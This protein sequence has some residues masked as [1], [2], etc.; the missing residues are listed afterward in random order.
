MGY[1]LHSRLWL[2]YALLIAMVLCLVGGAIAIV[3]FRSNIPLQQ[4][5]IKLQ[6]LRANTLPRLRLSSNLNSIELQSL[7]NRNTDQIRGRIVI[8]SNRGEVI[9]DSLS[10][11][12]LSLPDFGDKPPK[13]EVGAL[14]KFYRD[15]NRRGWYYIID[16]ISPN[17]LAFFGVNRPPLQLFAIFRDQYLRPLVLGGL[18]A[19]L[20]SIAFS[21]I[22][23]HW[24]STPLKQISQE[25]GQVA[26]GQAHPIPPRGPAEVRSLAAAFND[27]Y[28]QVQNSRQSQ[29]DFVAN[30][31]HELKTPLTSIQGFARAI[32]DG[33][34]ETEA[35]L[36][37]AATVIENEAGRMDRLVSDLLALAKMDA[38]TASFSMHEINLVGLLQTAILKFTPLIEEASLRFSTTLPSNNINI[39]GDP[40]RLMQVLD[41]LLVNAIKFT[42]ENGQISLDCQ[43][44]KNAVEIHV[45]DTGLGIPPDEQER[46]FERFYQVDKARSGD[47]GYGL[48]LAISKQIVETHGGDIFLKSKAGEGSHF[49]VKLPLQT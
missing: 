13:T 29:K 23:S 47:R 45:E 12:T 17:R 11:E 33:T 40:D 26:E 4:A 35:E 21:L 28:R 36:Q 18:I 48:G 24:I 7:L 46:I 6:T 43:I 41:N 8:L 20:A 15:N 37:Q 39:T 19:L 38:G 25:A 30:V 1:S 31:S 2:S 44:V 14:P 49:V 10:S 42:P 32:L 16:E 22:L 27:M 5:A 34:V 9:A 3:V